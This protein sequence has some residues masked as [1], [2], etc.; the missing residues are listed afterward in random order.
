MKNKCRGLNVLVELVKLYPTF[1]QSV[2][3]AYIFLNTVCFFFYKFKIYVL[4]NIYTPIC[5]AVFSLDIF[6]FSLLSPDFSPLYFRDHRCGSEVTMFMGESNSKQTTKIHIKACRAYKSLDEL[7]TSYCI[8]ILWFAISLNCVVLLSAHRNHSY[9]R[10]LPPNTMFRLQFVS[11]LQ[12]WFQS[13][14][15]FRLC[16]LW[17][18]NWVTGAGKWGAIKYLAHWSRHQRSQYWILHG[19]INLEN[20]TSL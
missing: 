11:C 3:C 7:Y 6:E 17:K 1:L 18:G 2:F 9:R 20:I 15:K 13:S 4:H 10:G 12:S 19:Q 5:E 14:F 16:F 8:L